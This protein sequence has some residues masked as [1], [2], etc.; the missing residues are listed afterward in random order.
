MF[1]YLFEVKLQSFKLKV[2]ELKELQIDILL[3]NVLILDSFE[4]IINEP[5]ISILNSFKK[6]LIFVNILKLRS[7]LELTLL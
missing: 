2:Y 3:F 1:I 5:F 7:K 4:V 6:M